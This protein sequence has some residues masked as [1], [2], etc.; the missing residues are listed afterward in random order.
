MVLLYD[1]CDLG[2]GHLLNLGLMLVDKGNYEGL[3]AMHPQLLQA[4][5]KVLGCE[6]PERVSSLDSL[7]LPESM[8]E[9]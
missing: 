7:R 5:E 1:V 6:L 2:M 8:R 9:A 3:E 4:R